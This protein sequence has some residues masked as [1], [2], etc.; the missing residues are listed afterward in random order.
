MNTERKEVWSEVNAMIAQFRIISSPIHET[1]VQAKIGEESSSL[2]MRGSTVVDIQPHGHRYPLYRR[3]AFRTNETPWK[4][5][6]RFIAEKVLI[7][8]SRKRPMKR[9]GGENGPLGKCKHNETKSARPT[10]EAA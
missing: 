2:T 1:T 9:V 7:G 5:A 3:A 4:R 10:M 8:E 6:E